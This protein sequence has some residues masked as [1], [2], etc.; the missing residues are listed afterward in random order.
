MASTY[1]NDLRLNE[2]ATGDGAGTWGTTTN[3]NLEL[4]GEALG[5]GTEGITTNADTHATTVADGATDPGR[6]MYIKYTGTLDSACTITIGPNTLSRVHIIENA[7]S[8]SQN[9]II[10]QGSGAEVTIANGFVK[11]VY[12]DGAGSGAAVTEAFTD[13]SV[14]G[15]LLIDGATP[16]LTIGDAGAEDTKIVFDG[17]AQDFYIGLDDS[18]DDLIIGLG[19]TV[20]TTPIISVDENKDVAIPDGSL[21]ITTD[22]NSNNLTLTSTDADANSGPNLLLKRDNNSAAGD[23][24][25]GTIVFQAEDAGNNLTDYIALKTMIQD[26]TGGS[27]DGRLKVELMSGG[28]ARNILDISGSNAVVFNEDSQD[29][30]FRVESNGNANMLFVDAG[31]DSVLVGHNTDISI[32]G[33]SNELQVYDTNFSLISAATFRAGSDGAS[34][35]LA[36]SRSGTIG[37]QTILQD[38]DTMGAIN[39]MGSDGTDM[40]SFGARIHAEVDG[41]P[42][43]NDMPGRLIFAT[44]S[45]GGTGS[46][47]RF[48]ISAGGTATFQHPIVVQSGATQGYYIENNAGNATTPRITN[49]ANDHTVIRPGKSGG[50]VQW[51]N[52]ANSAE[53][54]RLTDAGVFTLGPGGISESRVNQNFAITHA[55][56]RGGM[57]INSFYA[58]AAG[59]VF[60]WNKSRN[61]TAG[62]HTVVQSGDALGTFIWRGDDGDEFIDAA[63]I[64]GNVD[65][66]PGN[67]DMPGRIVFYTSPDGTDGLAERFRIDS[68]GVITVST[69]L[70]CIG[71]TSRSGGASIGNVVLEFGGNDANGLKIRD[72]DTNASCSQI[73]FI[74]GSSIVGSVSTS[75]SA[76]AFNTSSDYRLKENVIYDWEAL[77]TLT[78]LKPAKF[79]F[80]TDTD[81]TVEGFLAHEVSSVVPAAVTGEKDAM[82]TRTKLVLDSKGE[83]LEEGV[84]EDAWTAGKI[85]VLWEDNDLNIPEGVSVG[86]VKTAA[87]YAS[88]TTWEASKEYPSYQQIDQ[89]KL[90]P[91][92]VKAIQELEAKVK[93]LEES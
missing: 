59:P 50:A 20:G 32:A 79:N 25:T 60:D 87:K 6:A 48:R 72:T 10:K 63:A 7:T 40:A 49:D 36:H 66:T 55:A 74:S 77:S 24:V 22:D 89:S 5:Y 88:D 38:G 14:G 56:E 91:L 81:K 61:N 39:F 9:I 19:S 90:V 16:T 26:A 52:F 3:T 73:I 75:S 92:M 8:G 34:I 45:D 69:G 4:I 18:A 13:L 44:T 82:E 29:I 2:M 28:T 27:E 41:T 78:Q 80:K 51:N 57:A 47:E 83:V 67:G 71:T 42:G 84:E 31:N 86:D 93:A 54:L 37:T 70:M 12:L 64:E 62:S 43:S 21:T 68:G 1:V 17:N 23:D 30:D 76:T 53:L 15:N 11:A 35:S 58:N 65:G 85:P 33:E 46:T